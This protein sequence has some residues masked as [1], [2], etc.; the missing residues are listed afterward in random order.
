MMGWGHDTLSC[1]GHWAGGIGM[2][3][4]WIIIVVGILALA[5]GIFARCGGRSTV[6]PE[7]PLEIL[8]RRYAEG[9]ID[10]TEFEEKRKDILGS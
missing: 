10:K 8:K 4:F 6:A 9:E 3:L 5:R 7:S 1:G 2:F